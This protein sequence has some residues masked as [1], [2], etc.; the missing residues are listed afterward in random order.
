MFDI[1][2]RKSDEIRLLFDRRVI[3]DK[4]EC[5]GVLKELRSA[6]P[7]GARGDREVIVDYETEYVSENFDTGFGVELTGKVSNLRG[8]TEKT[9]RFSEEIA[10]LVCKAEEY[11]EA[12]RALHQYVLDNNFQIVGPT[13]QIRYGDGTVEVKLPVVKLY[14]FNPKFNEDIDIPFENDEEVIGR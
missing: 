6:V 2:I 7:A 14:E 4:T 5:D 11:D 10:G 3:S 9:V 13:Y 8:F 1:I 12:V